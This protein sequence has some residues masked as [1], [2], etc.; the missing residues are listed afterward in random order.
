MEHTYKK[1]VQQLLCRVTWMFWTSNNYLETT[2]KLWKNI[3]GQS[4]IWISN[5]VSILIGK[6]TKKC[7]SFAVNIG[8]DWPINVGWHLLSS[9]HFLKAFK[10]Q[11]QHV[12][13]PYYSPHISYGTA[14]EHLFKHQ[15]ISSLVIISFILITCMF[16]SNGNVRRNY[17]LVTIGA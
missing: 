10:P 16:D 2:Q 15:D 13:S 3:T 5:K 9:L 14:R 8:C 1:T 12:Y 6:W 11:Y 7:D 4:I 17:L